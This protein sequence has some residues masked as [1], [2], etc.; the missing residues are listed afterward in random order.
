M[1]TICIAKYCYIFR[2]MFGENVSEFTH[3]R[4][5]IWFD[6]GGGGGGGGGG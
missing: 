4:M 2:E 6:F 5:V 1:K 3:P